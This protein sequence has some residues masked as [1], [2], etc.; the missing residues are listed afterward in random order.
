MNEYYNVEKVEVFIIETLLRKG[1]VV[2]PD[3]G[4]LELKS[5]GDRRTV[6]FSKVVDNNNNYFKMSFEPEREEHNDMNAL[7]AVISSPLKEGRIVSLPQIGVFRPTKRENDEIHVSFIPSSF[8]RKWLNE[9]GTGNSAGTRE[10]IVTK[11]DTGSENKF[12]SNQQSSNFPESQQNE[13]KKE[14]ISVEGRVGKETPEPLNNNLEPKQKFY[15]PQPFRKFKAMDIIAQDIDEKKTGSKNRIASFFLIGAVIVIVVIAMF[16]IFPHHK[17]DSTDGQALTLPRGAISLPA[18]AEQHY[19]HPAFWI[20]IYEANEDKLSSP[21]NIPQNIS[22]VIPDLRTEYGVDV[23]DSAEI[24][25]AT[26]L[27][28]ILLRE[29][30]IIKDTN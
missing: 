20:Y 22:L 23:N 15:S 9:N 10:T 19:G 3:F 30:G 14:E 16:L 4:H 7:Y 27:A 28:D 5:L 2:I 17:N 25:K 29:K 8:L 11:I 21:V 18:L 12:S 24:R 6:L 1:S 13:I 26:V